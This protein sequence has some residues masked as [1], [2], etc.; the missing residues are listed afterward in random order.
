MSSLPPQAGH[1]P[2]ISTTIGMVNVQS[3]YPGQARK[4]PNRPDLYTSLRP[5]LGQISSL[6]SSGTLMR[7]PSMAVSASF[8]SF[9]NPP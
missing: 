4:R 2:G 8:I 3:G 7:T 9:S 5:Q 6:S 1:L